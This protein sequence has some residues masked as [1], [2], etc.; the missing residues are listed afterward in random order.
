MAGG[1]ISGAAYLAL[2]LVTLT[3][4]LR[5]VFVRTPWRTAYIALY[6]TFVAEVAESYIIDVQHWRHYFL[7]MGVLWGLVIAAAAR[8]RAAR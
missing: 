3:I 5:Y 7:I 6:A 8:R 1:W 4:G 2:T